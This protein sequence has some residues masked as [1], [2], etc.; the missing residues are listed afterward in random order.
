MEIPGLGREVQIRNWDWEEIGTK[1]ECG[2]KKIAFLLM[3]GSTYACRPTE[4][5]EKSHPKTIPQ[6]LENK[7]A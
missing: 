2:E 3:F 4:C 5:W 7:L 1:L 6:H